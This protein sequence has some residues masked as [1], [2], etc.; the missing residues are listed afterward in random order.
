MA[1]ISMIQGTTRVINLTFLQSDGVTPIDLT[2]SKV[3]FTVNASS[4]PASDASAA[5]QKIITSFSN[6]TAGAATVTILPADT[7]ALTAGTFY[8]DAK[9]IEASGTEVALKQDTFQITPAITR[10]IS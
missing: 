5:I 1:K 3:Y 7:S 9:A 8:Y 2:G 6:P 10:S 4:T